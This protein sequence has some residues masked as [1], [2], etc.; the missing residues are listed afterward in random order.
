M[1]L[2]KL[3]ETIMP[4][5]VINRESEREKTARG[6]L[7]SNVHMWWSRRPMAA[8]RSVLFASSVD[9]PAEHPELFP[10]EEARAQ[11]RQRL[12]ELTEVLCTVESA[13]NEELLSA[14]KKEILR[15]SEGTLPAVF[16]PFV[17]GGAIPVEAQRLG[18]K[19]ES[20]D[21][22]PVAVMITKL[23]TDIPARFS[24]TVPVHFQQEMKLDIPLPGAKGYAEDVKYYGDWMLSE[25]KKRIGYL[26]PQVTNPES[27]RDLEVSAWIWA[28]TVKCPNPSCG[29]DI[30]LSSSYDLAK[31]KGSEAWVEPYV[32][33]NT[34]RFRIHREPN[35]SEKGKPKV[36][37]T[38]VFKCPVCGEIT[39]DAYVKECGINHQI[40][41]QLIAVVADEGRK[42]LYIEPTAEQETI[43][44]VQAP[45]E[46]PHGALP[47]FPQRFSPPSFGLTD[48]ADLFTNRQLMFITTMMQLAREAQDVVEQAATV[49]GFSD[50]GISFAEGGRGALAYAEAVRMALVLTISKLLDRCSNLC[51]W[52]SS[53]G[54]SL[55]N[56]FSRA[57][58]PMIWDY[59]EGNPFHNASG[60]FSNALARTCETIA[61]LP[62]GG[63]SNTVVWDGTAP[64]DVHGAMISTELPFYDKASYGD[65][66]DFF[67]VWLRYGIGDLYPDY[68]RTEVTSKKEELT[69]FTYRWSG[70]RHQANAFYAEGLSLSMKNLYYSVTDE[71]PSTIAFQYK[72]NDAKADGSI[73]EWEAFVTS[74]SNAGFT[75]TASWPLGRKYES[76][77]ELAESRGIPITVVVRKKPADAPQITRRNF[78][79]AVKRELP[80]IVEGLQDKVNLMD[81]R[82]SVIGQALN[83]FTRYSKVLDADGTAMRPHLASQIIEQEIDT[84]LASVYKPDEKKREGEEETDHGG[85]S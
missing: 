58:M 66:S 11:E 79:A 84:I 82:A 28:R 34:V 56:V 42:R 44:A 21:L 76:S 55:R 25:A 33:G 45:K 13:S 22:N 12:L 62:A 2:K 15:Y 38:A 20:S 39:P 73:S 65:L 81:L 85:E 6:G 77:I 50:D 47:I 78:V 53:S 8:A 52:S 36:A 18:L 41:S 59:A 69:A 68:F 57:A 54:G 16:D 48:Y 71:Y 64:N 24:D 10:T 26:Y 74:V 30:P 75:I 49:K 7:P 9:D 14:A 61:E 43:A 23:V 63:E 60:S 83:I 31:K 1:P 32:D 35:T 5:T 3:I 19:A 29:C 17:G 72:G 80:S 27:G 37:Q 40:Y 51:S 46:V 4:V 67:Y 70:D